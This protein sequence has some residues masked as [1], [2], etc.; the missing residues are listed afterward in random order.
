MK[1]YMVPVA[2]AGIWVN[3]SEFI[4][5][6]V[7][8]KSVWVEG[9]AQLGLTFPSTPVNGAVWGLWGFVFAA[10][11]NGL[12]RRMGVIKG[13]L[14]AWVLGFVLMWTAMGNMGLLPS[15]LLA[16]AVPWSLG[17]VF[18]AAVVCRRLSR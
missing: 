8:L 4:R 10:V 5:N 18:V 16:W 7:V 9:F 12:V 17:E 14:A 11:L 6:E 1:Q 15:G 13:A 3:I 2:V